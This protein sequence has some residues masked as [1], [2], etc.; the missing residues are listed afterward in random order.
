MWN[1]SNPAVSLFAPSARLSPMA[2]FVTRRDGHYKTM[3]LLSF[4]GGARWRRVACRDGLHKSASPARAPQ[5]HATPFLWQR[6][7]PRARRQAPSR[8]LF[9][10]L[11][12]AFTRQD[13]YWRRCASPSRAVG[14]GALA[15]PR[16]VKPARRCRAPQNLRDKDIFAPAL[17]ACAATSAVAKLVSG[18]Y[19]RFYS[20]GWVLAP[21]YDGSE[22]I[23]TSSTFFSAGFFR[24]F[25]RG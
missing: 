13:G 8:N 24:F 1:C 19:R 23:K 4:S 18:A 21:V 7:A 12:A 3:R 15:P 2:L 20:T 25:R 17:A 16:R 5:N 14:P 6:R 9:P 22:F 10:A 11:I